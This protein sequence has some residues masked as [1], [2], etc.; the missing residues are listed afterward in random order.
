MKNEPLTVEWTKRNLQRRLIKVRQ[1]EEENF[2]RFGNYRRKDVSFTKEQM[3][4]SEA[5][6]RIICLVSGWIK[7]GHETV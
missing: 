7:T 3:F 2:R 1:M 5:H 6:P 4:Q